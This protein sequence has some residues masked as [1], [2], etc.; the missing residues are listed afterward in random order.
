MVVKFES[1]NLSS[2]KKEKFDE[3]LCNKRK[4]YGTQLRWYKSYNI[5]FFLFW[6]KNDT[7]RKYVY[8]HVYEK[9]EKLKFHADPFLSL[10][11]MIAPSFTSSYVNIRNPKQ[12][13]SGCQVYH[14]C[15]RFMWFIG[16]I[17]ILH[18]YK[19]KKFIIFM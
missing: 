1:I 18:I 10:R 12:F 16:K 19:L 2:D 6:K 17:Y 7:P 4:S 14:L 3:K 8:T 5:C 11:D 13:I 15:Q 9:N